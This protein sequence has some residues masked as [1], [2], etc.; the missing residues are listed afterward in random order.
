MPTGQEMHVTAAG[1]YEHVLK[2]LIPVFTQETGVSIQ[3]TVANAAGVIRRLEA[4]E[5]VDVVLTSAD[6]QPL[7]VRALTYS[8]AS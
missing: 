1:A 3:L 8:E 2:K 5:P 7:G 4:K 6:S